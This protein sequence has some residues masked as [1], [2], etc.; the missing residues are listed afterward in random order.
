MNR[1]V[2][3]AIAA[4]VLPILGGCASQE[5][6]SP[7]AGLT[8]P[9]D[10][11]KPPDLGRGP[12]IVEVEDIAA[13]YNMY[14][15]DSVRLICSGPDPFFAFD[16]SKPLSEDQPT[17]KNLIACMK[18]GALQGKTIKLI[19]HTDPRGTATYNERLGLQRAEKVKLF[20]VN[21]GVAP[22]RIQTASMGREDAA[23]APKEWAADRRV[24]IDLAP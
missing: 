20:L 10:P 2:L 6:N 5:P 22:D 23:R 24:Q 11:P 17:M 14:I 19:G 9:V 7:A 1:R 12:P 18:A 13:P 15:A 16:V 4:A 8:Q 21:N 3:I